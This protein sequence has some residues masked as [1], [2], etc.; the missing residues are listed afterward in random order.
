MAGSSGGSGNPL[1]TSLQSGTDQMVRVK[2]TGKRPF[3]D[4]FNSRTYEIKPGAD[5][6]V[7]FDAVC[8]WLGHPS[9]FDVSPRQRGRT[10]LFFRLRQRYGAYDTIEKVD[11]EDVA[12]GADEMWQRNQPHLEVYT[13][14]GERVYTIIDDPDGDKIRPADTTASEQSGI[15][16]RL[17]TLEAESALLKKLLADKDRTEGAGVDDGD[18]GD[19]GEENDTKDADAPSPLKPAAAKSR[20]PSPTLLKPDAERDTPTRPG[21][22]N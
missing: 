12:V 5:V 17:A 16:E 10:D 8:L 14:E 20:T 21:V 19:G 22:R 9:V 18:G 4:G 11:G 13:L 2:N 7:P 15:S 6:F 3:K 1:P